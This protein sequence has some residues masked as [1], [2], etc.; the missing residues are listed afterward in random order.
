[1]L[2]PNNEQYLW[3][4]GALCV[5]VASMAMGVTK[6]IH[7]PG[8]AA[9]LLCA[10]DGEVRRLGWFYIVVQ[11]VS[12]II[13]LSVACLFNN[14]QRRFPLYWWTPNSLQSSSTPIE[15]VIEDDIS[16]STTRGEEPP[17][18]ES[19]L[20]ALER[21]L[22][23]RHVIREG[24]TGDLK[25]RDLKDLPAGAI[26]NMVIILPTHFSL[27]EGLELTEEEEALL[28][29][30]QEQLQ[31]AEYRRKEREKSENIV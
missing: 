16:S 15:K 31:D 27:P 29:N 3:V 8:G 14:V 6:T 21:V 1:M 20:A 4:A 7:P 13:I 28:V 12:G 30:I 18:P 23:E 17:H 11:I 5:A 9:A 26:K 19:H 25:L 22:S 10:F 24:E 2:N